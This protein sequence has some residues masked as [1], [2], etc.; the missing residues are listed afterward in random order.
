MKKRMIPLMLCLLLAVACGGEDAQ[1]AADGDS[2]IT[3]GDADVELADN[4]ALI[5]LAEGGELSFT[6]SGGDEVT[7]AV[8]AEAVMEDVVISISEIDADPALSFG[9]VAFRGINL[10]PSGL[11]FYL[12]VTITITHQTPF[13]EEDQVYLA[14]TDD[15][16]NTTL[17]SDQPST[18]ATVAHVYHFSGYNG[19]KLPDEAKEAMCQQAKNYTGAKKCRNNLSK[20]NNLAVCYAYYMNNDPASAK[21]Y[22]DKV[23]EIYRQ[24]L[25]ATTDLPLPDD[26]YCGK[27]GTKAYQRGKDIYACMASAS[28]NGT[29]AML[30]EN[31]V[32][33]VEDAF[34]KLFTDLATQWISSTPIEGDSCI[35]GR[36]KRWQEEYFCIMKSGADDIEDKEIQE[37]YE[38]G[39][40]IIVN[41]F[42]GISIP[43]DE[44]DRCGWYKNCLDKHKAAEANF[45]GESFGD[46]LLKQLDER[47]AEVEA[48]CNNLWKLKISVDVQ[49]HYDFMGMEESTADFTID[50]EVDEIA[51]AFEG[52]TLQI[53]SGNIDESS[54]IDPSGV[55]TEGKGLTLPFK[56][57]MDGQMTHGTIIQN[58]WFYDISRVSRWNV[59]DNG[60]E[61]NCIMEYAC[62][63]ITDYEVRPHDAA[64]FPDVPEGLI[65]PTTAQIM[66]FSTLPSQSLAWGPVEL[67]AGS[68]Y[69]RWRVDNMVNIC[70]FDSDDNEWD[71]GDG[72][73]VFHFSDP[74]PDDARVVSSALD[75]NIKY[76]NAK[77]SAADID[78]LKHRR[79]VMIV[80]DLSNTIDIN[81]GAVTTETAESCVLTLTPVKK[82]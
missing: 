31:F 70:K 21:V 34:A 81:D 17:V 80:G 8:P 42:L 76:F 48:M 14:W 29:D 47:I 58:S 40:K 67:P 68:T 66:V 82:N 27:P 33:E 7:V 38:L 61:W 39:Y 35:E 59:T 63:N 44:K 4:E 69:L 37:N 22:M 78:N 74:H 75:P 45:A 43:S 26:F 23:T 73:E 11:E 62:D 10:E 57:Y 46:E 15:P 6:L 55:D 51:I 19:V 24:S 9:E 53:A 1:P 52:D 2:V 71:C 36:A 79:E 18:D 49:Q 5:T 16:A 41:E 60:S 28:G 3:D 32:K 72:G 13:S 12:P 65:P 56:I 54:G 20:R 64:N 77:L 50:V 30:D 25:K